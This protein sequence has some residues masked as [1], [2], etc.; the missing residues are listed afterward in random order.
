MHDP[1]FIQADMTCLTFTRASCDAVTFLWV[2][3]RRGMPEESGEEAA[4]HALSHIVSE[5][6]HDHCPGV[7][8]Y[9]HNPG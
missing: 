3:A 2:L 5:V 4:T 7:A 8:R 6:I 1:N 9:R